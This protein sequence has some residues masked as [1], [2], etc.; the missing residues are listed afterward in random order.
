MTFRLTTVALALLCA[1]VCFSQQPA[2][3]AAGRGG[4][5]QLPRVVSP[6]ILPDK[7]VTFRLRAPKAGEVLLNGNWDGGRNIP[8]TKDDAGI[9]SVT[10]GPLGEQLWGY[11]FSVDG[12]KVMDPGDGEYERD[13]N[14]YDNLLMI[15]GPASDLWDFKADVPHGT[16]QAV[17]YSSEILKQK[18]AACMSIRLP[19]TNRAR[20]NTRCSTCFMAAAAMK[21]PGPPWDEPT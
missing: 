20:R 18:A 13:G 3:Q 12:L 9:W 16:V 1:H 14:L 10:V 15:S 8:M 17:W 21:T 4:Q 2:G 7:K 11:S 6:E 19:G 5:T